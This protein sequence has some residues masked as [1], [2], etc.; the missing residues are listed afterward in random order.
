MLLLD[1]K[2]PRLDG[3]GVL[4]WLRLQPGLCRLLVVVFTSSS[5][6]KDIHRAF[7]LGANSYIVKPGELEELEETVRS[8]ENYW[9]RFNRCPDG[10]PGRQS[11]LIGRRVLLRDGKNGRYSQGG[12]RWTDNVEQALDLEHRERAVRSALGMRLT[13]I[14]IVAEVEQEHLKINVRVRED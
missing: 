2:M 3:F 1:L 9:L 5:D 12:G 11:G 8:L 6:E 13:H 10:A 7:E 4:E 14:E